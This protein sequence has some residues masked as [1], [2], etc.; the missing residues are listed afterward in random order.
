MARS[1]A[2]P[3]PRRMPAKPSRRRL[4]VARPADLLRAGF[5]AAL[6]RRRLRIA[7]VATLVALPLL[8][9]AWLWLRHSSLVAVREVQI[10]GVHGRDARAIDAALATAARRMSTLDVQQPALM[11]AVASFHVVSDVRASSSLPHG[12]HVYVAEQP[13]VAVLAADGATTA[14]A[15]N[16][17]V[18]GSQLTSASLPTVAAPAAPVAGHRVRGADLLAVLTVLGAAPGSLARQAQRAFTGPRGLTVQMRSGLLAYFGDDTLV[19]A[20]WDSLARVLADPT[21]TGASYV[22]VRVPAHPAAGFPAGVTPPAAAEAAQTGSAESS[23]A[24]ESTVGSLAAGLTPG[25]GEAASKPESTSP[26]ATPSE[27]S[28]EGSSAS[29]PAAQAP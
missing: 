13:P 27:A 28:G 17:V 29:E 1:I 12:L 18:L 3:A 21:S 22:D 7:L 2:A 6:Q 8:A 11:A 5:A 15:A 25:G 23:G 24:P 26:S 4:G 10:S 9:G 20:K 19:H 14:V 16:G